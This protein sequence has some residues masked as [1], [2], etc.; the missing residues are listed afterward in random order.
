MKVQIDSIIVKGTKRIRQ[1]PG[2]LTSLERSIQKVGLLNPIL[3]DENKKLIAG[4]RRLTACRNLGWKSIEA[5]I[6]RFNGNL[7]KMLDAEVDEN[8][9]RKD[10]TQEEIALIDK[11]RRYLIRKLK[12]NIFQRIWRWLKRFFKRGNIR[13]IVKE[14][15]YNNGKYRSGN[16][17]RAFKKEEAQSQPE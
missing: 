9:F 7:L 6:V 11:R 4:Y 15:G 12:G 10:F 8:L 13:R 3:L 16:E 14:A 1:D 5:N 2:D 17:L